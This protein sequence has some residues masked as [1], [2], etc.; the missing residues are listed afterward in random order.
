VIEAEAIEDGGL[1]VVHVDLVLDDAKAQFVG[2]THD[3]A[4][5]DPAIRCSRRGVLRKNSLR[6]YATS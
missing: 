6:C 3:R 5:L 2:L 4:A 1:E